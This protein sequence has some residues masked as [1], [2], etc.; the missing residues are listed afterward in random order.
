MA[1]AIDNDLRACVCDIIIFRVV[2]L[3]QPLPIQRNYRRQILLA[4]ENLFTKLIIFSHVERTH[5]LRRNG[6]NGARVRVEEEHRP[7]WPHRRR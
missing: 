7:V 1:E 3:P 2:A 5:V 4:I 6:E